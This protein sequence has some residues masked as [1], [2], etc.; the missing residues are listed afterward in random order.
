MDIQF[1][2]LRSIPASPGCTKNGLEAVA[3]FVPTVLGSGSAKQIAARQALTSACHLLSRSEG[4]DGTRTRSLQ[5]AV[6]GRA[7]KSAELVRS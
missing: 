5:H 4:L 1:D 3:L 2:E 7:K 6:F